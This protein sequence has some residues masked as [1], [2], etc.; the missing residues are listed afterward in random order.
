VSDSG[1][2]LAALPPG[3]HVRVESLP[4]EPLWNLPWLPILFVGLL[5]SEWILRK[6]F[7]LI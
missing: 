4:P 7:G 5:A 6:R 2:L 3:R 1:K